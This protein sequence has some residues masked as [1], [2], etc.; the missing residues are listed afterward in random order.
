MGSIASYVISGAVSLAGAGLMYYGFNRL[1]KYLLIS[2]I[3][4]ST[5]RGMAIGIVELHGTVKAEKT[6]LTPFSHTPC[7][8]YRYEIQE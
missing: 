5:I 1:Q 7:V 8:C 3:P 6:M 2:D 4:Q